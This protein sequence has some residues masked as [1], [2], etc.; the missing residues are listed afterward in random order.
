MF[1]QEALDRR[2]VFP[3]GILMPQ[4]FGGMA[5]WNF[6]VHA[7]ITDTCWDSEGNCYPMPEIISRALKN[8][9]PVL[10]SR[11]FLKRE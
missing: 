1:L 3:G 4:T 7:L 5:N 2:D 9:L 6:H 11:C 10:F 8:S